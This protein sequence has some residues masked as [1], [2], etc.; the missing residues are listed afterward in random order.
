MGR[1][2]VQYQPGILYGLGNIVENAV[3]FAENRVEIK[4]NWDDSDITLSIADDGPGFRPEIINRIG[5][6]YVTTRR[7]S[8]DTG[9]P[10]LEGGGLGLGFFI[11]KT[12]LERTG[13][14]IELSNRNSPTRGAVVQITWPRSVMDIRAG[15]PL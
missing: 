15:A 4:A 9:G 8:A 7:R 5:D 12:L 2:Y 10:A 6:P 13:A 11:A 3:D 14:Q 1:L